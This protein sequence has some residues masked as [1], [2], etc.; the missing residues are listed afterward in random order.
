MQ[1]TA[2]TARTSD[3][4]SHEQRLGILGALIVACMLSTGL[5]YT[6][7]YLQIEHYPQTDLISNTLIRIAIVL[8]WPLL[9]AAAIYAYWLYSHRRYAA[10]HPLLVLY[11]LLG[12]ATFGHFL[13]GSPHIPPFWYA[14]IFTDGLL[15]F[16][17]LVFVHWSV[18]HTPARV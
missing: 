10:A 4:L 2:D 1:A 9:T 15:G 14:T 6:H 17:I 13:F 7:N 16:C 18:T 12:L 8:A 5:H 3:A 11:S